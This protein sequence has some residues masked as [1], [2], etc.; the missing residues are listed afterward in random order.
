MKGPHNHIEI[1]TRIHI[2]TVYYINN[3]ACTLIPHPHGRKKSVPAP[4]IL[5]EMAVR[6]QRGSTAPRKL[7]LIKL[8]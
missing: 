3:A 7:G 8:L 2:F 1:Q 5:A 4:T 6:G